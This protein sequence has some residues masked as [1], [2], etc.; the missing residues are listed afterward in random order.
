M[1]AAGPL[2]GAIINYIHISAVSLHAR[3]RDN[4]STVLIPTVYNSINISAGESPHGYWQGNEV[5]GAVFVRDFASSFV[6]FERT[7]VVRKANRAFYSAE[8][9]AQA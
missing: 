8:P 7:A 2:R 9:M 6:L 4:K 3:C 1:A 5:S